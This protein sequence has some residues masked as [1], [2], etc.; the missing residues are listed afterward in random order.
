MTVAIAKVENPCSIH[1][2]G[3]TKVF[4]YITSDLLYI[5]KYL[6]ILYANVCSHQT[7]FIHISIFNMKQHT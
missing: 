6:F 2:A 4:K 3:M 7:F 5:L 1:L